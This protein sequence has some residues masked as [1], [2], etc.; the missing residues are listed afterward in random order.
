[1]ENFF[2][3]LRV[4][5]SITITNKSD[6]DIIISLRWSPTCNLDESYEAIFSNSVIEAGGEEVY[7]LS[8]A[9]GL[10]K[11]IIES[12][13][14]RKEEVVYM[15]QYNVHLTSLIEDIEHILCGCGCVNCPECDGESEDLLTVLLKLMSYNIINRGKY[16]D[17]LSRAHECVSC[18]I[19]T[20]G[21]CNLLR[22]NVIGNSTNTK[23]LRELIAFYYLCFY[24]VDIQYINDINKVKE[25]YNYAK[26]YPCA[27][28][29]GVNLKCIENT[30]WTLCEGG[31][32]GADVEDMKFDITDIQN[33]ITNIEGN[34]NDIEGNITNIEGNI[35][36]IE[37]N[38]DDIE[39]NI[40]DIEGN[41][42]D[43]ENEL[44]TVA[45]PS[46]SFTIID[47]HT[48]KWFK[49]GT[50]TKGMVSF[51]LPF[52]NGNCI[53]FADYA[54][55]YILSQSRESPP[56]NLRI[57]NN[58]ELYVNLNRRETIDVMLT[59]IN[60]STSF[61]P[62]EPVVGYTLEEIEATTKAAV[63]ETS[64]LRV[65]DGGDF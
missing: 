16:S 26:I 8:T 5:N 18:D 36:T 44:Q 56:A 1:M 38:I 21:N 48:G 39:G 42:S 22:E 17:L 35:T 62:I 20:I 6:G 10:Y 49:I 2:K 32:S 51:T 7:K 19:L 46:W 41:I 28:R 57:G 53:L 24:Y 59:S 37:G 52:F 31:G 45:L 58:G 15:P 64:D 40:D 33:N 50:F 55:G 63:I 23:L 25:M 30:N 9:D 34:I 4:Q 14:L 65:I 60:K 54:F 27:K 13:S 12:P 29:T 3:I 43:L 61:T 11:F 47:S